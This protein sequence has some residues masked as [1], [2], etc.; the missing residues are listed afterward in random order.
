MCFI[1]LIATAAMAQ[2]KINLVKSERGYGFKLNGED[3][4]KVYN[5]IFQQK[6][7]TLRADSAII[8]MGASTFDAYGHVVINQGDTLHIYADQLNYD[9]KTKIAILTNHVRMVDKDATLTTNYFNYNT[10]TKYGTYTDG[11]KLV[12]KDNVLTSKNGYYDAN[13]RDAYFRY[14]VVTTSPDAL[15]KTD[16]MRYNSGTRITY[17]YGPTHIYGKKDKD[18]LYTE[19]GT[20]N[21][22]TE[23]AF[24]GKKN[25]YSQGTKSLK[26]DSLFYD[27]LKGYGK[28]IKNITFEDTE[29][30]MLLK[31]NLGEYFKTE[32]KAVITQNPYAIL[33]TEQKD[34]SKTDSTKIAPPPQ[35]KDDLQSAVNDVTVLAKDAKLGK[36]P[37][38][39]PK[40]LPS[41]KADS[42]AKAIAKN[43]AVKNAMP[44]VKNVTPADALNAINTAKNMSPGKADSIAKTIAKMPAV[45][46]AMPLVTDQLKDS[47][48][49][50]VAATVSKN[51][52]TPVTDSTNAAKPVIKKDTAARIKLDTM[53]IGADTLET[54]VI[55]YKALKE[56]QEKRRLAGIRDTSIKPRKPFVPYTAKTMPKFLSAEM[57]QPI[58]PEPDFRHRP[59]FTIVKV[60][61]DTTQKKEV[62]T[63]VKLPAKGQP[64]AKP[65]DKKTDT[66]PVAKPPAGTLVLG[67][68]K[69][70]ADSLKAKRLADSILRTKPQLSDT[71]RVRILSAHHNVHIFKSDLQGK[72]DSLF[73][74]SSDSVIRSFVKPMYW[75]QGAQLSGDTINLQL[76][77]K[78]ADNMDVF[79]SAFV[80]HI[81]ANDSTHFNQIAGKRIRAYFKDS[82]LSR[83]TVNGNAENIYFNRKKGKI[84]EMEHSIGSIIELNMKN[85]AVAN[86]VYLSDNEHKAHPIAKV[87]EDDKILKGFI[88]KPKER[89]ASKE[90]VIHPKKP[91][92]EKE[93]PKK[94][95][96]G[97]TSAKG[98]TA[99]PTVTGK[100]TTASDG[101]D[102]VK[103]ITPAVKTPLLIKKDSTVATI[104]KV[105]VLQLKKDTLSK[106]PVD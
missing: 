92:P 26:G 46:N 56:L 91:E 85:G 74:S 53:Y 93:I 54:Q 90:D 64:A 76:K 24:F 86:I 69:L 71:S 62:L 31:G 25:R 9:D 95:A 42:M 28:A 1:V 73:Y 94:G 81:E 83:A 105:P 88:W 84:T 67:K 98:G 51:T 102:S 18:T 48:K 65:G 41:T 7:S 70:I 66:K 63:D 87:K 59:L 23:Q 20:Y 89:P 78:K 33:I 60:A 57:P 106:K 97:K 21:T 29:Q 49:K 11:G 2:Q 16:T 80:V 50:T 68:S 79:R 19:N 75:T 10:A 34:T 35:K 3:V 99:K 38:T 5:G 77:N 14:N 47:I 17:F 72:S 40:G 104:K 27:K 43:P 37:L 13:T 101:K 39:I 58:F 8:H 15:I 22:K 30:K 100:P 6:F 61:P 103:T 45:K 44:L 96:D 55:T 36:Q 32:D 12:N 82:K 52:K 4:S